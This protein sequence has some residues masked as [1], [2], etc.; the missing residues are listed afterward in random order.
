MVAVACR[1]KCAMSLYALNLF[2]LADNDD[3]LAYSRRSVAAVAK[4]G[5]KVVALGS[6]DAAATPA[7]GDAQPRQLMV[8]VEWPDAEAFAAFQRDPE[9]ADLHPLRENG[10]RNY[11][12]WAYR[13]L[14][15]LRP[16][17]KRK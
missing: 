2:D 15:D 3:Y 8:L 12:W 14:P 9:H 16:V 4:H 10:T 5:G 17:L 7:T 1:V 13:R 11:L 6:L